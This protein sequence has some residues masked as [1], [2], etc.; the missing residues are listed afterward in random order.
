[1]GMNSAM[2]YS[3]PR[4]C[5]INNEYCLSVP[6]L[7]EAG[8]DETTVKSSLSREIWECV[9]DTSDHRRKWVVYSSLPQVTKNKVDSWL[10]GFGGIE[11]AYRRQLIN[12]RIVIEKS[13]LQY[14]NEFEINGRAAYTYEQAH[15]LA[16]TCA[17]MRLHCTIRTKAQ[18]ITAGFKLVSEWQQTIFSLFLEQ[19]CF[20][21]A[22]TIFNKWLQYVSRFESEGASSLVSGK[23]GNQNRRSVDD[24]GFTQLCKLYGIPTKPTAEEVTIQYN[25]WA[26]S[27]GIAPISSRRARQILETAPAKMI[28]YMPR[29]GRDAYR[30]NIEPVASVAKPS[31]P[32]ALWV[33][34]GTRLQLLQ[35]SREPVYYVRLWDVYSGKMWAE[36]GKT[37]TAELVMRLLRRAM[38]ESGHHPWQL[39]YDQ[40]SANTAGAVSALMDRMV[41][42]IHF[43]TQAGNSRANPAETRI[44]NYEQRFLRKDI[45]FTGGNIKVRKLDSRANPDFIQLLEKSGALPKSAEALIELARNYDYEWNNTVHDKRIGKTPAELYA[46]AHEKRQPAST[47]D[48]NALFRMR[49]ERTISYG[50]EGIILTAGEQR[51]QYWV[52]DSDGAGDWNF[53]ELYLDT[54]FEIWYNS[55]AP[56]KIELHLSGKL[57]AIATLKPQFAGCVADAD[58]YPSH[59]AFADKRDVKLKQQLSKA[60]EVYEVIAETGLS[61]KV[62][63]KDVLNSVEHRMELDQIFG[64]VNGRASDTHNFMDYGQDA[65]LSVVA[66]I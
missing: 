62:L 40:G 30:N 11:T 25:R 14:F 38:T 41:H 20:Y 29:H 49:R 33:L 42:K 58:D 21:P 43:P 56:E 64:S 7:V 16:I 52:P 66:E 37:E 31:F 57:I 44:K 63:H 50:Q 39:K 53:R 51:V 17:Y 45:R 32:D 55:A 2:T 61:H 10:Q 27:Q 34:D 1:M 24:N 19:K 9:E 48:I 15:Q 23:L 28:W 5:R 59:H 3:L 4:F 47:E 12:D 18:A 35:G 26:E 60:K 65:D 54:S 6:A 13:D 22:T 36:Y 8:I 46:E